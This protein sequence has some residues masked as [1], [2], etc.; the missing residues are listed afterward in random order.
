MNQ[1]PTA[2]PRVSRQRK[3][4]R[5]E[6]LFYGASTAKVISVRMRQLNHSV[7]AVQGPTT[8]DQWVSRDLVNV[9]VAWQWIDIVPGLAVSFLLDAIL[10]G[11]RNIASS[12]DQNC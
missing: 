5:D 4:E 7:Y 8:Q 12:Q 1:N 11:R 2:E 10:S 6:M 3:K 9:G